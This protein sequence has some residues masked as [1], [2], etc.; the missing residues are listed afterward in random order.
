MA[1]LTQ[2]F[3]PGH[4]LT[5]FVL[6][7]S[8]RSPCLTGFLPNFQPLSNR[9][10]A[11]GIR[12]V[13]LS[14]RILTQ[15]GPWSNQIFA[16]SFHKLQPAF[17]PAFTG[18]RSLVPSWGIPSGRSCG[19]LRMACAPPCVGSPME[20]SLAVPNVLALSRETDVNLVLEFAQA[21]PQT[22]MGRL[23][24][25]RWASLSTPP[26]PFAL[27]VSPPDMGCAWEHFDLCRRSQLLN[28]LLCRVHGVRRV[29]CPTPWIIP[30]C[31]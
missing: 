11:Q 2:T 5:K 3:C 14:Y 17:S 8:T 10:F 9:I 19:V 16:Q 22:T 18:A 26:S 1:K 6:R 25:G 21:S 30:F 13:A 29:P 7:A 12:Q 31:T 4:C 15:F 23:W 27:G 28:N 24:M 20:F